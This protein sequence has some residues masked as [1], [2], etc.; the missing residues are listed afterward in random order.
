MSDEDK[1]AQ[2]IADLKKQVER[3]AAKNDE[4]LGEKKTLQAKIKA[5]PSLPEGFDP[6]KWKKLLEAEE[7][8][9]QEKAEAAGEYQKALEQEQKR[10]AEKLAAVEAERDK[11]RGMFESE[12]VTAAITA[13]MAEAGAHPN[14]AL[15]HV[16]DRVKLVEENGEY[17]VRVV[18]A[19]GEPQTKD[20]EPVSVTAML[21]EMRADEGYAPLFKS[22]GASGGGAN[23]SGPGGTSKNPYVKGD[24]FNMTEQGRLEHE[25]P[26][27]AAK[28]KAEAGLSH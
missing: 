27:L 14:L 28:Y 18:G 25:Q 26:Q 1:T 21:T 8:S 11:F 22:S 4:L 5:A 6:D 19:D 16:Q 13:A 3:L 24:S 12:K 10:S 15:P 20:G 7:R 2:Q 9:E 17:H 23:G